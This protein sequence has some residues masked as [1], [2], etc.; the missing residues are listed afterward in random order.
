MRYRGEDHR[1]A[2]DLPREATPDGRTHAATLAKLLDLKD[3]AQYGLAVISAAKARNAIKWA[4]L[5]I[6]SAQTEIERY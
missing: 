5:L 3:E 4:K 6:T 1:Q 2:A